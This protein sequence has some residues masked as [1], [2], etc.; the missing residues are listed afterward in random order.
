MLYCP[1]AANTGVVADPSAT[2]CGVCHLYLPPGQHLQCGML[3]GRQAFFLTT[4][5]GHHALTKSSLT[6]SSTTTQTE[7]KQLSTRFKR[8]TVSHLAL[9]SAWPSTRSWTMSARPWLAANLIAVRPY[10]A[11]CRQPVPIAV[12]TL[13]LSWL[14][15][16][17]TTLTRKLELRL[18][19]QSC[20]FNTR[21]FHE[22]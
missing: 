18:S 20:S 17:K 14:L 8:F 9:T 21:L 7:Y 12:L 19:S 10:I 5:S 22:D 2:R 3:L 11:S 6:L 1:N 13:Q 15:L 4:R 16:A